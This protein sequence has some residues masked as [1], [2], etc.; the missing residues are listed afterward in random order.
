LV[1]VNTTLDAT[2]I[3]KAVLISGTNPYLEITLPDITTVL[4]NKVL[5]FLFEGGNHIN[6]AVKCFGIQKI[7][8]LKQN[9]TE[10]I[11]GQSEQF[12]LFKWVDPNDSSIYAWR[13]INPDG[14]YKTAGEI[15][16]IYKETNVLNCIYANGATVSRN[17]YKRLW[18]HVQTLDSSMLVSDTDWNNAALN[19]KGKYSSGDGS[20]T[21]RLPQLYT[22]GFLRAVNS[23]VRKAGSFEVETVKVADD[24]KGVKVTGTGTVAGPVDN[25]TTPG[26]QFNL[27]S[28]YDIGTGTETKPA[29]FG[30]YKLIR[31]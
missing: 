28:A 15:V 14:N 2:I 26:N 11:G 12:G 1:D 19:N 24:V 29:N 7:Q 25:V 21:F 27:L 8:W 16:D 31:I 23:S 17:T 5:F 4:A 30:V 6:A 3:G 20:T 9:L 13:V 22:A 10:L 18:N